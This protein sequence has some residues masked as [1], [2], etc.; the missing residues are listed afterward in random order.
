MVDLE[1]LKALI[2]QEENFQDDGENEE[3]NNCVRYDITSYG[4]DFDV[5]GL[6]RRLKR[7]DIFV[8]EFQREYV[9]N[10]SEAS[11]F[12]ESL[13]LGLP[14]PGIFLAQEPETGKMLVIDGQQRLLSLKYFY[15]GEFKPQES[16][17]TKRVFRLSNVLKKYYEKTYET[18]DSRDK[19]NLDNAVIHATVVKQESPSEDD[20]SIYHIFERLNSGG[21]KLMPQEIRVAVYHGSLIDLA[22]ELNEIQVWRD[23][24][25]PKN[26]RMKDVELILR[27]FAMKEGFAS[28]SKP[29]VDFINRFCARNRNLSKDKLIYFRELF[30]Q[31]VTAFAQALPERPFR[32]S[33]A[34]NVAIFESCMVGLAERLSSGEDIELN[35]IANIYDRLMSDG[36]F[37]DLVY[38]STTDTKNLIRRFEI[39]IKY[40]QS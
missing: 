16:S 35:E 15:D 2:E 10:I 7:R 11:R 28:Y 12:I 31:T 24:F 27:F 32:L 36:E 29:M 1:A 14:V 4:I 30:T 22:K 38:Q 25:G 40:F 23:I 8:P 26:D 17:K 21:R 19:I 20:T 13:L 33:R 39:A 9:W 18:L 3:E 37:E 6:V 5:E 34:L